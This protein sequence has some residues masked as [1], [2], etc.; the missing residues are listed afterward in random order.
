MM[1]S[2]LCAREMLD[3]SKNIILASIKFN[4]EKNLVI[5]I[6]IRIKNYNYLN[7]YNCKSI[8][9]SQLLN[10]FLMFIKEMDISSVKITNCKA[11]SLQYKNLTYQYIDP[12]R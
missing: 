3:N 9:E 12:H 7:R 4:L 6:S 2:V 1:I 11:F 8:V 10:K 5:T